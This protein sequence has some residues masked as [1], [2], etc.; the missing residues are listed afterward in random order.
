[1]SIS[2]KSARVR[3]IFITRNDKNAIFEPFDAFLLDEN[4]ETSAIPQRYAAAEGKSLIQ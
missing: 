3:G 2:F 1:M 4:G